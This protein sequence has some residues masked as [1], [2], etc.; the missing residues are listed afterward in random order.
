MNRLPLIVL[1]ALTLAAA[2]PG[3]HEIELRLLH[4]EDLRIATVAYRLAA[5]NAELCADKAP[6][7]G[8][9]VHDLAQYTPGY[10][11]A[12]AN[13]FGL[14]QKPAVSAVV[15]GSPAD[16][17]G[18]RANDVFVAIDG[19]PIPSEP[20]PRKA[21]YDDVARILAILDAAMVKGPVRLD[22]LRGGRPLTIMLVART[23]CASIIQ[24]V[25]SRRLNASADGKIVQITTAIAGYAANDDELA[26]VIAHEMAHNAL[27]HRVRLDAQGVSR[28]LF[29]K[30]G[31]NA[32]AIRATEQEADYVGV[33]LMARAGYRFAAAPRFWER[34]G[35]ER[36]FGTFLDASHP[37]WGARTRNL[38]AAVAEIEA[39]EARGEA[40]RPER[41][42]ISSRNP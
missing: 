4:A 42:A 12:A 17:A 29:G 35:R 23:G 13:L 8:I 6:L 39:K 11:E 28:G 1:C 40:I 33:Y 21:S 36:G 3:D 32:A 14:G 18:L 30:F 31:K 5:A 7:S 2:G 15:R 27:R 24:L 34:F 9:M 16:S 22:I 10:R 26:T 20:T 25:P 41:T 38:D 19:A 37:G